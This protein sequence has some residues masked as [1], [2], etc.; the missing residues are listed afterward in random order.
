MSPFPN[1]EDIGGPR[2]VGLLAIQLSRLLVPEY[3]IEFSRRD[4]FKLYMTLASLNRVLESRTIT[5]LPTVHNPIFIYF[6]ERK[7]TG[8]PEENYLVF[9][10]NSNNCRIFRSKD[11]K[12]CYQN[13]SCP[14]HKIKTMSQVKTWRRCETLWLH[15]REILC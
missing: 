13:R 6:L 1:D 5:D 12:R 10:V 2:N 7:T 11:V 15:S 4:N 14:N 9:T 8:R 3:F